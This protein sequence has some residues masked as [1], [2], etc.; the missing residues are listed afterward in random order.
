MDW[1][2]LVFTG[3]LAI[4]TGLVVGLAPALHISRGALSESL[5]SGGRGTAVSVSQRLRSA[6]V[7]GEISLAVLLVIAAG[8]MIRSFW[9]L[10]HVNPGFRPEHIL[11][12][13]ITPNESFCSDATRGF[14]SQP[15]RSGAIL[16]G[17]QW[18]GVRE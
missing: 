4:L 16:S 10:S 1:R 11:T 8:L 14:L 6:L 9:A 15:S 17:R 13:R 2:V 12:A 3:G 5:K 18:R 7:V